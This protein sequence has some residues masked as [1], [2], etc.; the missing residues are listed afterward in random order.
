MEEEDC[1]AFEKIPSFVAEVIGHRREYEKAAYLTTV[2]MGY[3]KNLADITQNMVHLVRSK[4]VLRGLIRY[5][6]QS[7]R[8]MVKTFEEHCDSGPYTLRC[9]VFCQILKVTGTFGTLCALHG[10]PYKHFNLLIHEVL[11]NTSQSRRT[12]M[13]EKINV[14]EETHES[15]PPYGKEKLDEMWIPKMK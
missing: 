11:R 3:S 5:L 4:E 10:S 15:G 6:Y 14:M 8:M 12:H 9:N 13:I 1:I 2:Y 7:K